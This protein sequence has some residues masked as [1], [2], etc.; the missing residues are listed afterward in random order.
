[1]GRQ[2]WACL[3]KNQHQIVPKNAGKMREIDQTFA[4]KRGE[5]DE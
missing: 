2:R 4:G 3:L 5:K 1:V